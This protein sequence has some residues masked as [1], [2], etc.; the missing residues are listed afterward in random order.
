[1][2]VPRCFQ[3]H[4]SRSQ[5]ESAVLHCISLYPVLSPIY[6]SPFVTMSF[7]QDRYNALTNQDTDS[8]D[9]DYAQIMAML[10]QSI[11]M[12]NHHASGQYLPS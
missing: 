6:L 5:L 4:L 10:E 3:T 8:K 12:S 2:L 1:M 9:F 11:A 7:N